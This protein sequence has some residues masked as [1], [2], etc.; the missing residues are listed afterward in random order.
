MGAAHENEAHFRARAE[1]ALEETGRRLVEQSKELTELTAA[2]A[3]GAVAF[4][5]RL[6]VILESTARTLGVNRV[7]VWQFTKTAPPSAAWIC[8]RLRDSRPLWSVPSSSAVL[9]A[10]SRLSSAS[11]S[12]PLTTPTLDERTA[13][14]SGAI[15]PRTAS[16]PCSTSRCGR[17][18]SRWA[19][20]VSSTLAAR[21]YGVIDAQNFALSVANLIAAAAADAQ[22]RHALARLAESEAR[23]RLIVDTAHDAF[24]GID[25]AGQIIT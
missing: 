11:A 19:C 1:Q 8:A 9:R 17:M 15:S 10:I 2:H 20:C 22:R 5:E 18:T 12:L 7:S 3:R 25:S 24:I 4:D 23:A 13:E 16:G 6:S 14:F 21:A